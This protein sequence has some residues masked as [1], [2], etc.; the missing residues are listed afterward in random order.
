M[1]EVEYKQESMWMVKIMAL[2]EFHEG[3]N[4]HVL[5]VVSFKEEGTNMCPALT[6]TTL[7]SVPS[8]NY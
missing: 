7:G 5:I 2:Y 4:Y 3:W 6:P 8:P 1:T